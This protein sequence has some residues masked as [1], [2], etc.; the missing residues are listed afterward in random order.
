M[1]MNRNAW[2]GLV[3]TIAVVLVVVLGFRD[4]GSPG[5][6]RL[7]QMDLNIVRSLENLAQQVNML[8]KSPGNVLPP[9]LERIPDSYRRDRSTGQLFTYRPQTNNQYELCATFATD[10]MNVH[11]G[12]LEDHWLHP[13]GDYCFRF[14][15]SQPV[16]S[17]N[18]Y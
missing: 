10:N 15:A 5:T 2:A 17:V 3:A 6:Q 16:P 13:K 14:D 12:N 9:N 8:W 1:S 4:L 18:Y 11:R 7:V